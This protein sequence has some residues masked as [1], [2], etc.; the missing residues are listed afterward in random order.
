VNYFAHAIR[1]L[2][3]PWFMAGTAIPDWLNVVDRKC[4]VRRKSVLAR[5]PELSGTEQA[6]ALGIVQH[7]DDDH[8]FHATPAFF[9]CT[10]DLAVAFRSHLG[11]DDVWHCGFLGHIVLELLLDAELIRRNPELLDRYYAAFQAI[12]PEIVAGVVT[13]LATIPAPGLA[14]LIPLYVKERFLA[15][16]LDDRR[17]LHRLNQVMR[18]V[19]LPALPDS[20]VDVLAWSREL[21][22]VQMPRLL[23]ERHFSP[24]APLPAAIASP[25]TGH[26]QAPP[27]EQAE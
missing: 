12:D 21:V 10:N 7:L 5:L 17:L 2:D 15:D 24:A 6:V 18:R 1:F 3:R 26:P 11:P 23:P 16:Y 20:T 13:R 8:W 27:P 25:E 14:H 22:A 9:E 4:R 19:K